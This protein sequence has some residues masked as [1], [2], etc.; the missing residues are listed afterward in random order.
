M[1]RCCFALDLHPELAADY[2]AR[3]APG[4]VW[5]AVLDHLRAQGFAE[6]EIWHTGD[7]LFM[8][9]EVAPDWPRPV[10]TP[11]EV[12]R[13][14]EAM[15]QYQRPLPGAAPGE[16]WVAMTRVFRFPEAPE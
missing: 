16:K 2:A 9:A 3:H 10:P 8:V 13:W 6:M 12:E 1:T 11:P 5:P 7:R 15:W 4:A 14:E